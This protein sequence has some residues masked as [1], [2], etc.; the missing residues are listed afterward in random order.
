MLVR[1]VDWIHCIQFDLKYEIHD[2]KYCCIQYFVNKK[3]DYTKYKILKEYKML[4]L[5]IWLELQNTRWRIGRG[6]IPRLLILTQI[7]TLPFLSSIWSERWTLPHWAQ[8]NVTD[9]N[10]F[11]SI[12]DSCSWKNSYSLHDAALSHKFSFHFENIKTRLKNFYLSYRF[13]KYI[14]DQMFTL[15]RFEEC[16]M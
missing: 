15:F 8:Y 6:C 1:A 11:F 12:Q 7:H 5:P 14:C 13:C 10:I 9:T 2:I 4:R 3:K 16:F